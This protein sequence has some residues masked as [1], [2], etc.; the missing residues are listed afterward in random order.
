MLNTTEKYL[1]YVLGGLGVI[2]LVRN[3][4]ILSEKLSSVTIENKLA[5]LKK[6]K[7]VGEA[8]QREYGIASVI[9]VGQACLESN[10]GMSKLTKD[11][12][13]L[14]GVKATDDWIK[15]GKPVWTGR[16]TEYFDGKN[17]SK[18]IDGFKK[19]SS[20]LASAR[21]WANLISTAQR[22]MN[23]YSYATDGNVPKF[24]AEVKTSGYAT[25]PNY[26]TKYV[27]RVAEV[28]S[29]SANV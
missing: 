18:V 4:G 21:D 22:Y 15:A 16:T 6:I 12:N 17:A 28:A 9:L 11:A 7:P 24:G 8:I 14:F 20:W 5:F 2:L 27:A 25:D 19:Y 3:A 13:N 26:K 1:T 10:W 23:L 29:L